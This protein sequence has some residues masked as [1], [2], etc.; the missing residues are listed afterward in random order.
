MRGI[1]KSYTDSREHNDGGG[2]ESPMNA[3][4]FSIYQVVW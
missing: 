4:Y 2:L 3:N 1:E